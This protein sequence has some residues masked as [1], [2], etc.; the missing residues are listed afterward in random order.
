MRANY[1]E[2]LRRCLRER[3]LEA[4]VDFGDL[5]VFQTATTYPCILIVRNDTPASSFRVTQVKSLD[6]RSLDEYGA[7][8]HYA[9]ACSDLDDQGWSLTDART[10]SL[11]NKLRHRLI[12]EDPRSVELIKPFLAGR[13]IKRYQ[14]P[15]SDRY[16][17]FTR[18][19]VDI[20]HYPAIEKHLRHFKEQLMP[21]P[22]ECK[23]GPWKGRKPGPYLWHEIQDTVAYHEEFEKP[24]I[25]VPAIVQR[26]SYAFDTE[27]FCSNDKTSIIATEDFYLLG[28]LNSRV[29]DFVMHLISST[30]QSGYFEYK[31]MY[32]QQLPIRRIDFTNPAD[33]SLHER[34]VRLVEEMLSIN[35]QLASVRTGHERTGLQRQIEAIDRQIDGLVYEVCDLTEDE[36]KI[37]EGVGPSL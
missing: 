33:A 30:K 18:R 36:I 34:L 22:K 9:V 37:I 25:I 23:E 2:R 11:L 6:F 35:R 14:P 29:P 17:I 10:Q 26:A 7:E 15:S 8:H 3:C 28:V 4:I 16:L 1:G 31:P 13:D 24:K 20:G 12:G 5:P 27:G 21:K 19:G 32:L